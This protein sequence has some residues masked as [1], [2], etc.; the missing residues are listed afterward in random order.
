MSY[1]RPNLI[2]RVYSRS[3]IWVGFYALIFIRKRFVK[4][5][6]EYVPCI[7]STD[8]CEYDSIIYENDV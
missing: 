8:R 6:L 2:L 5:C 1:V 7:V 4:I 3:K